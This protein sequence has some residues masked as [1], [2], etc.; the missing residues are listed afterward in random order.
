MKQKHFPT[1]AELQIIHDLYD[2]SSLRINKIMRALGSKY[3]RWYVRRKARE[4]GLTRGKD[5]LWTAAEESF[6]YECYPR[7]G[8]KELQRKLKNATGILRTTTAIHLKIKRLGIVAGDGEGFT[9]RGLCAFLWAGQEM[10]HTIE[11]WMEK[12]WLKGRRRGTLRKKCQGGDYWYFD[13]EWVRSFIIAHPEEIDLRLVDPVA[14]IRLLAGD[15]EILTQCKC[16]GCGKV[17]DIRV[18][19]PGVRLL[20][21][22]C[23]N[24]RMALAADGEPEPFRMAM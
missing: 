11:R 16:P 20:R 3:P 8:L 14:F 17:Y 15:G 10:H 5:S 7:V 24:C 18:F 21:I 4:M 22:Y 23:D 6:V 2:G 13:P 12:G 19:N 1:D 9:I